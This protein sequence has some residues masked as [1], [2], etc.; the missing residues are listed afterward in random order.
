MAE[1]SDAEARARL[2]R[3]R[4]KLKDAYLSGRTVVES[5]LRHKVELRPRSAYDPHPWVDANGFRYNSRECHIQ[6]AE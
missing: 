1:M 5:L 2:A 3:H 4:K 6:D